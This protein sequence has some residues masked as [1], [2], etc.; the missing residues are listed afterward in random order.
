VS[1][2]EKE[3]VMKIHASATV[4]ALALALAS[5][6]AAQS[7]PDTSTTG[8][9]NRPMGTTTNSTSGTYNNS[10]TGGTYNSTSGTRA[11]GSLPKTASPMP[12]FSLLGSAATA[13]GLWLSQ[14]RRRH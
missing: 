11:G 5:S 14:R 9:Y 12:L 3:L 8:T 6:A 7:N 13:A 4:V 1:N 2:L 10:T